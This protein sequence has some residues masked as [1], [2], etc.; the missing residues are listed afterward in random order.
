MIV[1]SACI[2]IEDRGGMTV[3][4]LEQIC[5]E[6]AN[7]KSLAVRHVSKVPYG[8]SDGL[9]TALGKIALYDITDLITPSIKHI[10]GKVGYVTSICNLTVRWPDE[11]TYPRVRSALPARSVTLS[12]ATRLAPGWYQSPPFLPGSA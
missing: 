1:P 10:S 12:A 3:L 8:S 7:E 9:D 5:R 6:I 2:Y 11:H 4:E